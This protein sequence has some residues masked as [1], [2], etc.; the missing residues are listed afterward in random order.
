MNWKPLGDNWK[1]VDKETFDRVL[2][3]GDFR[4][5]GF[6]DGTVY[7]VRPDGKYR[8]DFGFEDKDGTYYLQEQF[9]PNR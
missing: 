1:P 4:R 8:V 7:F 6:S 5:E 2:A 3:M 9:I